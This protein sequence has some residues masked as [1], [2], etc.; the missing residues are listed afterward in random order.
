M[1]L[2]WSL[3]YV[4]HHKGITPEHHP[5]GKEQVLSGEPVVYLCIV[6]GGQGTLKHGEWLLKAAYGAHV[7]KGSHYRLQR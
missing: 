5:D 2:S 4:P 1:C 6:P 7:P 3:F